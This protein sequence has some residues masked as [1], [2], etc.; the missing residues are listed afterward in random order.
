MKLKRSDPNYYREYRKKN[1]AHLKAYYK[2]W[3]VQNQ[4]IIKKHRKKHRDENLEREVVKQADYY[5]KNKK[6]IVS[7]QVIRCKIRRK[8]DIQYKIECNLR[9][10]LRRSRLG[11]RPSLKLIGCTITQF[12]SHIESQFKPG[13]TWENHGHKTW[14]LDHIKP[15]STFD[16]T[17]ISQQREC[18]HFS[19]LRPLW[20]SEN[21]RRP[22]IRRKK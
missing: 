13:M 20:A 2:N 18:F 22:K 12:I 14:H 21:F 9:S 1:L 15:I 16:L 11:N 10:H 4:A 8:T 3:A 6:S 7:K 19:N 17:D 5:N